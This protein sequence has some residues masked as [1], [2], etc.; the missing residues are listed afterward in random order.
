MAVK[1]DEK[2]MTLNYAEQI[3]IGRCTAK[4]I[5]GKDVIDLKI[6]GQIQPL[7]LFEQ[8]LPWLI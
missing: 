3:C 1:S 7:L 4:W 2:Q 5:Q 8:N 6:K